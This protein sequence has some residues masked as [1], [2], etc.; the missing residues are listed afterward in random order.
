MQ[1][2]ERVVL[3]EPLRA[4]DSTTGDTSTHVN[5]E[6]S[7]LMLPN[8]AGRPWLGWVSRKLIRYWLSFPTIVIIR[9][10]SCARK[11][12]TGLITEVSLERYQ[13][14]LRLRSGSSKTSNPNTSPPS[15]PISDGTPG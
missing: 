13:I 3:L 14:R 1:S 9:D 7:I 5:L 4:I 6:I 10:D 8:S 12:A 11:L 15:L 2:K